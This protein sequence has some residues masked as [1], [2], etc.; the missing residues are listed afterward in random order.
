MN[1]TRD[2]IAR[3]LREVLAE[4][5]ERPED[6]D[7]AR[8]LDDYLDDMEFFAANLSRVAW[9]IVD[10]VTGESEVPR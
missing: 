4:A 1:L 9:R 8:E 7:S 6:F 10:N 5:P 3:M 2:D